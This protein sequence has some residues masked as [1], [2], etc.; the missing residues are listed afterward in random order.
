[1]KAT[2]NASPLLS[3]MKHEI[4]NWMVNMGSFT[5]TES[6]DRNFKEPILLSD[7]EQL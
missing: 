2:L 5:D 4:E 1:M 7:E 6:E 3:L